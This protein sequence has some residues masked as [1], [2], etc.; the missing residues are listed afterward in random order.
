MG[1]KST[2]PLEDLDDERTFVSE[3]LAAARVA[4]AANGHKLF[5]S[6]K[7]ALVKPVGRGSPQK[8]TIVTL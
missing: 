8:I 2:L 3:K 6:G 7:Q 5:R 1:N 4:H